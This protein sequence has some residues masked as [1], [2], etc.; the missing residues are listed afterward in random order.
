MRFLSLLELTVLD[1]CLTVNPKI[2]EVN[3]HYGGLE[4][5][6]RPWCQH[7]QVTLLLYPETDFSRRFHLAN[8]VFSKFTTVD[9]G[10]QHTNPMSFGLTVGE[11]F[12]R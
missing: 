5:E 7:G 1:V 12:R 2:P 8:R 3:G 9:V 11:K 10:Q 4:I 6:P